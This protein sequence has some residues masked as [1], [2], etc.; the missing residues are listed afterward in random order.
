[1]VVTDR[2]AK[3]DDALGAERHDFVSGEAED[4]GEDFVG[5][6]A[7]CCAGMGDAAASAVS[8]EIVPAVRRGARRLLGLADRQVGDCIHNPREVV[9]ADQI[10]IPP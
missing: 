9:L 7:E 2:G 1:M 8:Q 4:A 6:A 3:L 5:V 10:A